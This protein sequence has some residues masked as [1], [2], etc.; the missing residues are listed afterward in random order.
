[1][2]VVLTQVDLIEPAREWPLQPGGAKARRIVET[3]EYMAR[4]VLAAPGYESLDAE[5]PWTGCR[6][7]GD[8]PVRCLVPIA[9]P[10]GETFWN[11]ET[12]SESI[13]NFLPREALLQFFQAQRRKELL[14][15]L[16]ASLIWRFAGIAGTVGA[17][18]VPVADFLILTPL[19]LVMIALVGGI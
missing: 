3:L 19:Q 13:G 2:L 18:P 14:R 12:L 6:L 4:D 8:Q 11:I 15:K 1:I 10:P 17:A 9:V 7:Q 5:K 16:A